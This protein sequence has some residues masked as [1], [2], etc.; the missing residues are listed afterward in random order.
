MA[1]DRDR[2]GPPEPGPALASLSRATITKLC[3][4][5]ETSIPSSAAA[6]LA[7]GAAAMAAAELARQADVLHTALEQ[8]RGRRPSRRAADI[9]GSLMPITSTTGD[10]VYAALEGLHQ[11]GRRDVNHSRS[12]MYPDVNCLLSQPVEKMV[13]LVEHARLQK[14][15]D[16]ADRAL[17]A[18]S[19]TS[20]ASAVQ[21][22]LWVDKYTPQAFTE[23]LS[24]EQTN[25]EVLK[26]LK[27]WDGLVFG[28]RQTATTAEVLQALRRS[29]H[30]LSSTSAGVRTTPGMRPYGS[31]GGSGA[32][33]RGWSRE[34]GGASGRGSRAPYLEQG[35]EAGQKARRW[36]D[37]HDTR[38]QGSVPGAESSQLLG[39]GDA[40]VKGGPTQKVIL[41]C[42]PPGLGKT[43]LA[44]IVAEHCGYRVVEIN[45]SDDRSSSRLKDKMLDAVQMQPVIT[46]GRPNCL[47]IDEIDGALGGTDGK[48]AISAL[49]DIVTAENRLAKRQQESV[50][51]SDALVS[52]SKKARKASFKGKLNRPVVCIC[53]DLYAPVLR[54]LREIARVFIFE[55]PS[56]SRM[57]SRLKYICEV[58]GFKVDARALT[59]LASHTECDIRSCLNTLQFL[60]SKRSSLSMDVESQIVGRKD[61]TRNMFRIWQEVFQAKKR[62]DGESQRHEYSE[63]SRLHGLVSSQGDSE[64]IM[65]GIHENLHSTSYHDT[66]FAKTVQCMDWMAESDVIGQQGFSRQHGYL[67]TYQ[68]APVLAIRRMVASSSR[69][70]LRWPKAHFKFRSDRASRQELLIL[71]RS[72]MNPAVFCSWG[73]ACASQDLV[74]FLLTILSPSL[75]PVS[76]QLLSKAEKEGIDE[77]VDTMVSLG[78]SY[79]AAKA[80]THSDTRA[81]E[82]SLI[83]QMDPPLGN[84]VNY[85]SSLS[86]HNILSSTIR[87]MLAH[88]VDTLSSIVELERIRRDSA[89]RKFQSIDANK[90]KAETPMVLP[91]KSEHDKE[92]ELPANGGTSADKKKDKHVYHAAAFHQSSSS[93]L[94]VQAQK[95]SVDF[96]GRCLGAGHKQ[97][98]H[99]RGSANFDT[100]ARDALP[101]LYKYHE[102]FTNAVRRPVLIR[103]LL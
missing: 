65:A 75:R 61:M 42:G 19:A 103:D 45:A 4:P 86:E 62:K 25:R 60:H 33:S 80:P 34:R 5:S 1:K 13:E 32:E 8:Q 53:N 21:A 16:E 49:L 77:L 57:V 24:D 64:L 31:H 9:E 38:A 67:H 12:Q 99:R 95:P 14:I 97:G 66:Y 54:P 82:Q 59:A 41:L 17:A 76:L 87:Q 6:K 96:F 44:H 69:P 85:E 98:V 93:R 40:A 20:P 78:I 11:D 3:L 52:K 102:G 73:P 28:T 50:E 70:H 27:D 7:A 37:G 58:E 15:V 30:A 18:E 100:A 48:G 84:L 88:E 10:R 91:P 22:Q 72:K 39:S 89:S 51:G 29:S 71:W 2:P 79:Q 43:T 101:V 56:V 55:P 81:L 92:N 94:F 63:F 36:G 26:W 35:G 83:L 46:D 23:L 47:I 68:A 90:H 74:S